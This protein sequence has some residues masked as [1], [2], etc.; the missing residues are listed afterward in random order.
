[1]PKQGFLEKGRR[2]QLVWAGRHWSS[3]ILAVADD[4]LSVAYLAEEPLGAGALIDL[5]CRFVSGYALYHMHVVIP[6]CRPGDEMIVRR[7]GN[8]TC[9]ER[10]RTWRVPVNAPLSFRRHA[11]DLLMEGWL[12]DL[13]AE[14]ALIETNE[15]LTTQDILDLPLPLETEYALVSGRV[16]RKIP[17][18][19]GEDRPAR[20]GVWFTE[21]TPVARGV[22]TRFLWS[23]IRV[24]Y[25]RELAAL[26]PNAHSRRKRKK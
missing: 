20:F 11:G 21:T 3:E 8:I 19:N 5:E 10:R 18:E 2:V 15:P 7:S 12:I 25:P 9:H 22:L 6:P 23:R 16:T 4:T 17:P 24:L 14:G 26:F 1:M 13:S